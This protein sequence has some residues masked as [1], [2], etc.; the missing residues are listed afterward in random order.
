MA[1]SE[2]TEVKNILLDFIKYQKDVNKRQEGFNGKQEGFNLSFDKKIDK[3]QYY[4][5]E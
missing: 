2:I 5:E 4:L 3:V 1:N